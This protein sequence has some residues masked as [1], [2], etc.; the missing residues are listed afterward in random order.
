MHVRMKLASI[1]VALHD[2]EKRHLTRAKERKQDLFS[3]DF[4]LVESA[5]HLLREA[6]M[7]EV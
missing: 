2:A 4:I 5:V 3:W 6:V 1:R 7:S